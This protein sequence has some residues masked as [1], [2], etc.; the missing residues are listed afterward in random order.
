VEGITFDAT[1]VAPPRG[2]GALVV[3]PE[4]TVTIF[5]TRARVPVRATFD[6]IPYRGSAVPMGDGRFGL[7]ITKAIRDAAGIGIGDTVQVVVERDSEERTVELP[8]DLAAAL[9]A[10]RLDERF[11]ALPYT[12]R[13]EYVKWITAA[14][15]DTTR[16]GRVAK[17]IVMVSEGKTLS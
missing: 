2:Q 1:I 12:H 6:G 8:D 11:A 7:G 3:M 4:E 10:A 14:K 13:R 17:A 15:R 16:A 5:G 9:R